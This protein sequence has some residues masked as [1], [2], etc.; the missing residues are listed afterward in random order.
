M[1][2]SSTEQMLARFQNYTYDMR[3]STTEV[4]RMDQTEEGAEEVLC[5]L[6]A[7][8]HGTGFRTAYGEL[9]YKYFGPVVKHLRKQNWNRPKDPTGVRRFFG[10]R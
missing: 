1:P 9:L 10:D 6:Y 4:Q 5:E 2:L 3:S 8:D 7:T